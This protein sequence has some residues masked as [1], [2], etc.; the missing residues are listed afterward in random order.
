MKTKKS[1]IQLDVK[2]CAS[3]F[4]F[5][6]SNLNKIRRKIKVL[7]RYFKISITRDMSWLCPFKSEKSSIDQ[8]KIFTA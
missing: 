5:N 7:G 8:N 3:A 6:V 1:G 4:S 2:V